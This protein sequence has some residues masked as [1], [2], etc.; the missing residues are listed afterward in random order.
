MTIPDSVEHSMVPQQS[1]VAGTDLSSVPS[2]TNIHS[3][4]VIPTGSFDNVLR[5]VCQFL[6]TGSHP[7]SLIMPLPPAPT[8]GT[9]EQWT[10]PQQSMV[11]D[12]SSSSM[13]SATNI[14]NNSTA[15]TS[16][17]EGVMRLAQEINVETV[18]CYY[19]YE[20]SDQELHNIWQVAIEQ[21]HEGIADQARL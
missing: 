6:N 4:L 21:L 17:S 15:Q 8:S 7:Y 10:A 19:I 12:T 20:Y 5:N 18:F 16:I 2:T 1:M 11:A 13:A 14:S 3:G 9:A